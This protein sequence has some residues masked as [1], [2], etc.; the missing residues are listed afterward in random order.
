[1]GIQIG[2]FFLGDVFELGFGDFADFILERIR[3]TFFRAGG[4]LDEFT[5]RSDF[6]DKAETT[7]FVDVDNNRH[8]FAFFVL[9]FVIKFFAESLDVHAMLAKGRTNRRRRIRCPANDL[10]FDLSD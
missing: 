6:H 3:W 8:N 7:I 5:R 2:H 9:R 4:F 1:M 10:K